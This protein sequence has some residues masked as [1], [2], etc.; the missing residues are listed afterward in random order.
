MDS[1]GFKDAG[2]IPNVYAPIN[3]L[4]FYKNWWKIEN[5]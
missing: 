3:W 1:F 2:R 4:L 5:C